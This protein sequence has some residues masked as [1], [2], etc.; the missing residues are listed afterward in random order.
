MTLAEGLQGRLRA[1]SQRERLLL[2]LGVA[3]VL[4]FLVIR[5]GAYPALDTY[6]KSRAAIPQKM[7][8][9]ARY[10]LAA[11][12]ETNIDEAFADAAVRLEEIEEGM[13]PGDNP[14]AAGSAL[15]GILKPWLERS[16]TR[17]TS[18]RT[19]GPVQKGSYAEVAVQMD[20]Q[21]TTEGL[22]ALLA[23]VPRHPKILKV[24]KLSVASGYYGA[25]MA[26]RR[27]T[28]VVSVVVAGMASA[29]IEPKGERA[30]E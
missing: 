7:G 17:L 5:W 3:A 18:V 27:E 25:G 1:L 21:T 15:Q 23:E 28:L 29:D 4:A 30:E 11:A 19:L 13:L 14:A 26:N 24:K 6:R 16:D 8:T 10:R 22:A 9:L 12:G 2:L 20:L